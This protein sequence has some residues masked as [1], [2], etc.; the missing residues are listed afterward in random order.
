MWLLK[1]LVLTKTGILVFNQIYDRI[2]MCILD[3]TVQPQLQSK[4]MGHLCP[5]LQHL[6]QNFIFLSDYVY[7][8]WSFIILLLIIMLIELGCPGLS[9]AY[10]P[11]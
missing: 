7:G 6:D 1:Y 3:T 8:S 4:Y 5:F 11:I 2:A 10:P 9:E